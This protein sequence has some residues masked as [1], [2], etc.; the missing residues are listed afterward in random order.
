MSGVMTIVRR[1][2]G[3][4][5]RSPLAYV[6]LIGFVGGAPGFH[7]LTFFA[8]GQADARLFFDLLPWY[9]VAFSGFI[10]MRS[11]AEEQQGN[12]YEMLLTFPMSIRQLVL[13]KWIAA[14]SFVA[15]GIAC[16]A[17]V[18]VMVFSVGHPDPG[19][20]LAGYVG[21]LLL[22]AT[23]TAVGVFVSGLT[24][25]QLLAAWTT[26]G[27]G[28]ISLLVGIEG[29]SGLMDA[30]MK[31]TG[32][33]ASSL[34]GAWGHYQVFARGVI[35]VGDV[36][37]FAAWTIVFLH[38]N[39]VLIGLRRVADSW[40][41]MAAA[42]ALGLGCGMFASRLVHDGSIARVDLTEDRLYTLSP[43]T[44]AILGEAQVPVQVR[45]YVSPGSEMPT[46]VKSLERDVVDRLNEIA[47]A[48]HG[49]LQFSVI[50]LNV[51]NLVV[52]PGEQDDLTDEEGEPLS[53]DP[54]AKKEAKDQKKAAEAKKRGEE[55]AK[56]VERR[57]L[58]KGVEPFTAAKREATQV[59]SKLV[60]STLGVAYREKDEE[61]IT[62]VRPENL[63][64]IEYRLAN[65]VA[66][67]T[68]AHPPKIALVTGEEPMDPQVRMMY[69][70]MGQK[71]PDPYSHVDDI[72]RAEK[73][74]VLRVKLTA[75]EQMPEDYDALVVVGPVRLD[76]RQRWEI[77]R[78]LVEGK[79]T[80]LAL[81]PHSWRYQQ[82]AR[83]IVV[84][85]EETESGLEDLLAANGLG[86]SKEVLFDANSRPLLIGGMILNLPI[87]V[88][89]TRGSMSTE[90]PV[91]QRLNSV[92]YLW[93]S[94]LDLD[95]A[96]LSGGDLKRSVLLSSSAKAWLRPAP[97]RGLSPADV[98]PDGKDVA[99]RPLVVMAEGQFQDPVA[100]KPRPKWTPKLEMG[101]D[102]RPIPAMPDRDERPA[103]PG[104]G[105]LILSGCAEMWADGPVDSPQFGNASLLLNCVDALTLDENLMLVRSKQPTDRSFETP[106]EATANWWYTAALGLVP[107]VIVAAGVGIWVLRARRRESWNAQHGRWRS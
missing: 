92:L 82:T 67:M 100:G 18:P 35:E 40:P 78:A 48:S 47:V 72:L 102:G 73:L 16:T 36:V 39:E 71:I 38:M 49:K 77:G 56:S 34:F 17:M 28:F 21:A 23:A 14:F 20:I 60:Y 27:V 10:T 69:E 80:L 41:R 93:G 26:Q 91:T 61:F 62:P 43:G 11:W 94:S 31:G 57:L 58:E 87:H 44:L 8:Q 2:L 50:H 106:S 7:V 46:E 79:P 45:Y 105:K 59:S 97:T 86:V 54:T 5:F 70:R 76:E 89:V 81:Q 9:V 30:Q 51:E 66:K 65:V 12:T 63:Q 104:K 85:P 95:N 88:F 68:R 32:S 101:P 29:I 75:Q 55:K 13:A 98:D 90:S 103:A 25:T 42:A 99:V 74:D 84:T 53:L 37:F 64:Q 107:L 15:L 24:R 83:G 4:M 1:E 3:A 96:K 52:R 6:L 19:P 33:L 22:A